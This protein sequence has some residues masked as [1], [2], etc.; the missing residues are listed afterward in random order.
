MFTAS[1]VLFV[2][3]LMQLWGFCDKLHITNRLLRIII[4]T[5]YSRIDFICYAIGLLPCY[6]TEYLL[7]KKH[8]KENQHEKAYPDR[9]G[10]CIGD[11]AR[12]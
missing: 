10:H 1:A 2:I 11:L 8:T 9:H 6:V 7:H 12:N 5:G 4:G 3:E